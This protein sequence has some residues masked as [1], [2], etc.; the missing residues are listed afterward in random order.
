MSES[1]QRLLLIVHDIDASSEDLI[2][3]GVDVSEVLHNGPGKG[4]GAGHRPEATLVP[5][6]ASFSD[7]DGNQWLLQQITERRPGRV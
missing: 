3:R 2:S 7:V 6:P 1:L 5:Q 4:R